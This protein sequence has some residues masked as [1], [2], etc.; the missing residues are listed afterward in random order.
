MVDYK[1]ERWTKLKAHEEQL[2]Y[3][4]SPHRFNVLPCGRRSGKTERFKRKLI[5]RAMIGTEHDTPRFFAAAPTYKQA[6]KIFWNDLKAM[7]P[8]MFVKRHFEADLI[9][10]LVTGTEIHLIGLDRPARIE[11]IP[12]DGGGVDEYADIKPEA[13]T[14]NIRPALSDRL[15]WCDFIG[16]PE[17]R[18]HYYDLYQKAKKLQEQFGDASEWGAFTWVSADILPASEIESAKSDMDELTFAQEYEASFINFQ[19]LAYHSYHSEKSCGNL[20]QNYNPKDDL[21]ITFDFNVSPG[22]AAIIQEMK[23]PNGLDGTAVIGEVHIPRSS[24]TVHVCNKIINDWIGHKGNIFVYGD[25]TGGASGSAK[26]SGSDWD[27]IRATLQPA[28]GEKLYLR[29]QKANPRERVR[30]N[31][32]NSRLAN[33]AGERRLMIDPY[34]APKVIEDFEGVTTLEGGSGEIDKVKNPHLSHLTDGI[35]YYIEKVFPIG[36]KGKIRTGSYQ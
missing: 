4:K 15:G 13:W 26:V 17:G 32:V 8:P 14:E 18:N 2:R 35:G 24:N 12:W 7:I 36:N 20:F 16:V 29:N 28:F 27:L 6:K 10:K 21:I 19:G 34:K 23:L 3:W 25:A 9:I 30:V 33:T 31:A 11:G 1:T 5:R 22:T